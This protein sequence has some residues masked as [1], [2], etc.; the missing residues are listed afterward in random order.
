MRWLVDHAV[1]TSALRQSL[2]NNLI[3]KVRFKL[4]DGIV[5]SDD[6]PCFYPSFAFQ[7]EHIKERSNS[8]RG[9]ALF[10]TQPN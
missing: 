10:D 4:I 8:L 1:N 5:Q 3:P 7:S 9:L 2:K 6:P